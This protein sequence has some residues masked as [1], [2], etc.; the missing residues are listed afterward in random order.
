MTIDD[1]WQRNDR[2]AVCLIF[3]VFYM[4]FFL[5]QKLIKVLYWT[6]TITWV[7][8]TNDIKKNKTVDQKK[9]SEK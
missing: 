2:S 4:V 3:Y 8:V 6:Q 7:A 5:Y 9:T 1:N